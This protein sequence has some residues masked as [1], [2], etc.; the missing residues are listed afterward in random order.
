MRKISALLACLLLFITLAFTGCS[1]QLP[2]RSNGGADTTNIK[3]PDI[4]GI[5]ESDGRNVISSLGL[6]P[7]VEYEHS[8]TVVKGEIIRCEPACGTEVALA[9]KVTI[10]VSSG[11]L[12]IQSLDSYSNWT[13]IRRGVEDNWEF[14]DPYIEDGV[15]Y[16]ACYNVT[17]GTAMTWRDRYNEGKASGTASVNDTFDK[18]VPVSLVYTKQSWNAGESQSFVIQVPLNDLNVEK[19]TD[20]YFRIGISVDGSSEDLSVN[21]SMSWP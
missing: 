6:I 9:S 18:V 11:P 13:Y 10:Y 5:L 15:L 3:V 7:N 4:T 17:F 16:I 21:F 20:L 14:Y 19:P 2:L 8:D 12:R 1:A